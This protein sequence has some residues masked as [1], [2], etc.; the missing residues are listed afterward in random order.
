MVFRYMYFMSIAGTIAFAI[1]GSMLAIRKRMDLFGVN[2]LAVLTAT[3]GGILR[4]MIIGNTPPEMFRDPLHVFIAIITAN[5]VFF[6]RRAMP[7]SP[8]GVYEKVG[9]LF[10]T[11][12]LAAFTIN[13][14]FVGIANDYGDN[15]FLITFLG[16]ITGVGGGVIRD[17]LANL[18]PGIFVKHIYAAASLVGAL[19]SGI[20]WIYTENE[21]FSVVT[22][23]VVIIVL[24]GL[25]ARYRWSLPRLN[26]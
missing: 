17:V 8:S 22:G 15:L 1:S 18:I 7:E 4:D 20:I 25:A 12:G 10:D 11:L 24:R 5:I 14:V 23:L 16:V 2:I 26:A 6:V 9:F 13:G 3:G 19:I 21:L